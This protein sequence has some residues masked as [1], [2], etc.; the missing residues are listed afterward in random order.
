MSLTMTTEQ[1][2]RFSRHNI[3]GFIGNWSYW[4]SSAF[5]FNYQQLYTPLGLGLINTKR[6]TMIIS[7]SIDW[8]ITKLL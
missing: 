1:A 2:L 8:A 4:R 6:A 5:S 7:R 3:I